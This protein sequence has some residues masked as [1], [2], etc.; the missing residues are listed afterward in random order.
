LMGATS[1]LAG[2]ESAASGKAAALPLASPLAVGA[3]AEVLELRSASP[4]P[5]FSGA[6]GPAPRLRSRRHAGASGTCSLWLG[7]SARA[8]PPRPRR[9]F[10][11]EQH[12]HCPC[13]GAPTPAPSPSLSRRGPD[14][15]VLA[16]RDLHWYAAGSPV[17][18]RGSGAR[19]W[20]R[21]PVAGPPGHPRPRSA[22][23]PGLMTATPGPRTGP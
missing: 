6:W 20:G 13:A 10:E 7:Y 15:R 19:D 9:S 17:W 3:V 2:V 12:L 8:P 23:T 21:L 22:S 5:P 16:P 18:H 1:P 4:L 11:P 14:L